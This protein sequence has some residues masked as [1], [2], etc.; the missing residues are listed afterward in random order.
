MASAALETV[1][2][3]ITEARVLLQ[4]TDAAVYRYSTKELVD[5]L[6]FGILEIKRLRADLLLPRFELPWTDPATADLSAVKVPLDP[7]YR[8]SLVFY[9][10]GRAQLR[11]DEATTDS[12][13]AGLMGKFTSQLM[14]VT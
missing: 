7:M 9:I 5:A 3:Y 11:D 13:A 2:Q 10:V 12:R 6:N 4:D 14:T 8:P 1:D